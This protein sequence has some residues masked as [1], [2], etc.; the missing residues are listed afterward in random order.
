MARSFQVQQVDV[1]GGPGVPGRITVPGDLVS[2]FQGR[3]FREDAPP[4]GTLPGYT[5]S[6]PMG[7]TQ[8]R[9]TTFNLEDN[10]SYAGR[11]TVYTPID[12]P[13]AALNPSSS[14]DGINTVIRVNEVI[15]PPL[16]IGDD[17]A[18][19]TITNI[20]TYVIEIADD[21]GV[22][23]DLVIPPAVMPD[24][25][26][27]E[28]IG[29]FGSPWGEGYTQNFVDL[30]Q[31]FARGEPADPILGQTWYDHANGEFKLRALGGSWVTIGSA[32]PTSYRHEQVSSDDTWVITHGLN[33][34][35]PYIAFVQFFVLDAGVYKLISPL[36]LTFDTANQLTVTFSV[37]RTGFALIRV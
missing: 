33:L 3:F 6:P 22:V 19:G 9:A 37:P 12:A 28:L 21:A 10:E 13:D 24:A 16:N 7:Y 27:V 29:R 14:F 5:V 18:V 35:A 36:D 30:A 25:L 8:I 17:G 1:S 20:S 34:A 32:V 4:H 11:Y 15:G 31:N 2:S 23:Q 26:P